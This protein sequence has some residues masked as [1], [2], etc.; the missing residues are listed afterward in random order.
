MGDITLADQTVSQT[1]SNFMPY[2]T[3]MKTDT[4][5]QRIEFESLLINSCI[6]SQIIYGRGTKNTQRGKDIL[7]NKW[8]WKN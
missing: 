2:D 6:S 1:Y 3:G 4:L 5:I 7:F 8:C